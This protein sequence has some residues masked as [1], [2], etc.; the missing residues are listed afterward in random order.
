MVERR[1]DGHGAAYTVVRDGIVVEVE[2]RVGSFAD[3]NGKP[4]V[5]WE[6]VHRQSK[7]ARLLLGEDLANE[8]LLVFRTAAIGGGAQAPGARLQIEVVDAAERTSG[9]EGVTDVSNG[10]LDAAF[11]VA[12]GRSDGLG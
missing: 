5:S 7:Q 11:F 3:L 6:V 2:A 9:E 4:L 8:A 12:P 10:A 1:D